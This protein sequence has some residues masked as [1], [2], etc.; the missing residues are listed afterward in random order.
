MGMFGISP[1]MEFHKL[2]AELSFGRIDAACQIGG[3]NDK[4]SVTREYE[5]GWHSMGGAM[6]TSG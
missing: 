2:N 3:N 5:Y 4:L 6:C 1:D